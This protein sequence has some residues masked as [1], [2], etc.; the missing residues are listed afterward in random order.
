MKAFRVAPFFKVINLRTTGTAAHNRHNNLGKVAVK[1]LNLAAQE[2][3]KASELFTR[4]E[5]CKG[6]NTRNLP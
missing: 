3:F 2:D 5:P 4:H 1:V 6:S